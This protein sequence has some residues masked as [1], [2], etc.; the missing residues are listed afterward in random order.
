[1][2]EDPPDP[3]KNER[4]QDAKNNDHDRRGHEKY[5]HLRKFAHAVILA[6][7]VAMLS[8]AGAYRILEK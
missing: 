2:A 5:V 6:L 7:P 1:M 4:E 3:I 8:Q